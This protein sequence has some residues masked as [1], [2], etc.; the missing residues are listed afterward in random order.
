MSPKVLS[1]ARSPAP[2]A[3]EIRRGLYGAG[4]RSLSFVGSFAIKIQRGDFAGGHDDRPA[5]GAA[6]L[7]HHPVAPTP[8]R[9]V[10]PFE[11][12]GVRLPP[13]LAV[14]FDTGECFNSSCG[15]G[16]FNGFRK[17]LVEF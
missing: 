4:E 7:I 2:A 6:V 1:D 14:F 8:V 3:G 15:T 16:L 5:A 9:G 12:P 17:T 11:E 13:L 10:T